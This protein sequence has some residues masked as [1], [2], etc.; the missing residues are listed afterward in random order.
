MHSLALRARISHFLAEVVLHPIVKRSTPTLT[1]SAKDSRHEAVSGG[2]EGEDDR[3]DFDGGAISRIGLA[4]A[5]CDGL[6]VPERFA[7]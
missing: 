7:S 5:P 1:P 4:S 3:L 2:R 6:A